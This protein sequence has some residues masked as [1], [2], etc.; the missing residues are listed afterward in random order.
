MNN[1]LL[2]SE[3]Y[4]KTNST[5]SDNYFGKYLTPAI[6]EAQDIGLQYILG[7]CLYKK[8]LEL[9]INDEIVLPENAVYKTLVDDFALNYLLYKVLSNTSLYA[10]VKLANI[11]TVLTTDEHI[12][13]LSQKDF[14]LLQHNFENKASF[15]E[16]RLQQ[17][18]LNNKESIPELDCGC[19]CNKTI[20]PHLRFSDNCDLYLGI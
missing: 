8:V 19:G 10:N 20:K 7:E 1:V 18:L 12:V 13:G 16:K 5:I 9:V 17:F 11:G 4:I 3:D 2:I 15:Y 14:D 6:V